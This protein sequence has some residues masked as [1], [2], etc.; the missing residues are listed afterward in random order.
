MNVDFYGTLYMTKAFLPHFLKGSGANIVNISSMGGLFPVPG[1]SIYGAAKAGVKLLT[2]GLHAELR[3]TNVNVTLI[4]PGGMATDIKYNSGAENTH[5]NS[6]DIKNA[7]IKLVQPAKAA[8]IIIDSMEKNKFRVLIGTDI[9]ALSFLYKIA[10]KF[11]ANLV[12]KQMKA[13][14]P[15]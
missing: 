1:E 12:N 13:H 14:V 5:M 7:V 3:N 8:N 15:D 2:E 11:A 9:K 4:C 6:N 10:P